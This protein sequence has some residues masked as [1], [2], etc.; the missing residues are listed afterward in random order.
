MEMPTAILLIQVMTIWSA[1]L[2]LGNVG[3]TIPLLGSDV[4]VTD[5]RCEYLSDPIG[6]DVRQPRLSWKLQSRQKGQ[7]Q[8]AYRIVVSSTLELLTQNQGDLWDSGIVPSDQ[9]IQV[10]YDGAPLQ[11]RMRCY[12][13]V[14]V[15]D[16][17]GAI[18]PFSDAGVWEMG[19]LQSADWRAKWISAPESDPNAVRPAPLLRKTFVL[20]QSI[21]KA[22]VYICGLGYYELYL[23]GGKVGNH[24]LD[25]A[26]TRYDKRD[27][28]VTYDVTE[29]LHKGFNAICVI[30]GNGWYN[31]HAREEWDFDK[32][33]WRDRPKLLCQLEMT[34]AD[35][36][37]RIIVSDETWRV[38]SGP[39]VFDSIRNGET[40]D[41][42]LDIPAWDS[43]ETDDSDWPLVRIAT[44][45]G[46]QLAAQMIEPIEVTAILKPIRVTHP[47]SGVYVFDIG[48]NMAGWVR[49][50]VA[51]PP[52]TKVVMKYAERLND[53]GTIDQ[54]DIAR[55]YKQ[56]EFQTDTY[57]LQ[58]IGTE[59]WEPRFVYHGFRYVQV[60]GLS[61]GEPDLDTIEA[62]VVHTAFDSAGS[63]ECSNELLNQ[64]QRN[65]LWS[66]ISNFQGYP[67]DC[68]HR[69]KNGWT[70]DAHLAAETG[71]YNF[72]VAAA[73][74]KWMNDFKDEQRES[75]ELP[76]IVPTG[77]W[78]YQW[79]NG[80]A[81]DSAYVLIPWYLYEYCGDARILAEHYEHLKR[82][83]DYLTSKADDYIVSIGLGDWAPARSETPAAITSTGYYYR[84]AL[85]VSKIAA[86][87]GKND[88]A[89]KYSDLALAIR[90]AFNA[91]F[92]HSDTS[93]YDDGTQTAMSCALYQGLVPPKEHEKVLDN[94]VAMIAENDNHLDAGILGTKY[95]IDAL[96]EN[97]RADLVYAMAT[98]TT[99][100]SWGYWIQQGATTLWEQ[101]DGTASRN[102]IM[103]GHIST[104]LY[105]ALAGIESDPEAVGFKR[106]IIKPHVLGDL[107][108]VRAE[109]DSMYGTIKSDWEV[110]GH[111]FMLTASIP[112]N[113]TASVYVPTDR[114]T[115]MNEGP[116]S[117]C[118]SSHVRF[119]RLEDNYAVFDVESGTYEFNSKLPY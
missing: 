1:I 7:R 103:F 65:T 27:L 109:H 91:R 38:R 9:S 56:Y 48:Q 36:S 25:P 57:I 102:H 83:V 92:Y 47:K 54:T 28:Y 16:K 23:N 67:T 112:P 77:G 107:T 99:Y 108:W 64:I 119:V 105:E 32:A 51:G 37:S 62:C 12:W 45:P 61:R 22:R 117:I 17:D 96:T 52:G 50:K 115:F 110:H 79:G 44:S 97:G 98:Q 2:G 49:L 13:K 24:V 75:G 68:P 70:G 31:A 114:Q 82:Y 66:Y 104:W 72:D 41:A 90:D 58:G 20:S 86:M 74:T 101:W 84:D 116:D 80:P 78:G 8:T 89:R 11:S 106:T 100:P 15:W 35:G 6:I 111:A 39:I 59:V 30:L 60:T 95:L 19:L 85:I 21:L 42:R 88:D 69:E 43:S 34:F 10:V 4:R 14:R 87:L 118:R 73:Y 33:P 55:F 71:L 3:L 76:G 46:G 63:F 29:Q 18:S 40:Y 93:L 81:W 26:F 5:L 113:T 94:L 53:D